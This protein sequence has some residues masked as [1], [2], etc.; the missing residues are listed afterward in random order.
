MARKKPEL[1]ELL[2]WLQRDSRNRFEVYDVDK[3]KSLEKCASYKDLEKS[4]STALG[5]FEGL[6]DDGIQTIQIFKKRK[7]GTAFVREGCGLNYGISTDGSTKRIVAASGMPD[8][9]ATTRQHSNTNNDFGFG[10]GSPGLG[11]AEIMN[12]NSQSDR[13][14]ELKASNIILIAKKEA[15]EAENKKLSDSC[16][17]NEYGNANKPSALDKVLEGFAANPVEVIKALKGSFPALSG[18][19]SGN[20]IDANLSAMKSRIVDIVSNNKQLTDEHATAAIYILQEA[21]SGNEKFL[22]EY[23]ELLQKHNLIDGN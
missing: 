21:L 3:E 17:K 9:P 13:Y 23:I 5:Y 7:N 18:P 8:R 12:M 22:N 20:Q 10:L 16:L 15:L 1:N 4:G 6:A 11:M 2:D 19:H 14:Q